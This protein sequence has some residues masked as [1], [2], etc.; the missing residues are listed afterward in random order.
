MLRTRKGWLVAVVAFGLGA[1]ACKKDDKKAGPA[2]TAEST[3]T[4]EDK[5]GDKPALALPAA[6]GDDLS[7]LPADS[8]MVMG[9]NFAQLQQ[10][11]L[12]K[13]FAPKLMDKVSGGLAEF[14]EA[15]GFDPI[16]AISSVSLGMKG[17]DGDNPAG[18]FVIHGL[19]KGKVMSCL[20]KAKVEA[21]KKGSD[22]V[23]DGDVFTVKDEGG[24]TSAFTFVGNA[25]LGVVGPTASADAAREAAK[26]TS[27]LKT[28]PAFVELYSKIN[29]KES[30]WLLI[31]GNAPFMKDAQQMGFKPKA[32]YGSVNVTDGLTVDLRVRLGS[33]DEASQLVNLAK[34]Q[35]SSPQVKQFFDKLD[36]TGDGA[37]VKVAVAMS[38]A[39]LQQVIQLAGGALGGLMGGM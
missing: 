17:L 30:L 2:G 16:V 25:L 3:T 34:G 38:S 15:C 14:K 10:S 20:D 1:G 12:W 23:I 7:L 33:S 37:D 5:P 28:S 18:A 9:L 6:A 4:T 11:A 39:K 27:A 13:Q 22:L 19:D 8:E 35:T 26:G 36:V 21:A 32:V 31:N 29:T 24:Q